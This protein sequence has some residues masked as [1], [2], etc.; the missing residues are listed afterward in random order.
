MDGFRRIKVGSHDPTFAANYYSNSKKLMTRINI[1]MR[2]L[3]A[4]TKPKNNWMQKTGRVNRPLENA[5]CLIC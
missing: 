3:C 1:S 5:G 2:Q 4:E